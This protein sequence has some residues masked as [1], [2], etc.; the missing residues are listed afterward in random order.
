MI[1]RS[2]IRAF[3]ANIL[4]FYKKE[5]RR[6]P[7]RE[8]HDPYRILVSEIMLQ[9]TQTARVQ[10]KYA[11]FLEC[12][13]SFEKLAVAPRAAV[14]RAWQGLGYNRR[15]LALH[16]CACRVMREHKGILPGDPEVLRELPG[17]GPYT[18]AAIACFAWSYPSAFI[19][20][21]IRTVFLLE[22]FPR[23]RKVSDAEI[24][25]LVQSTLPTRNS[26][27]WYYALM[28]YG[29]MLK[30]SARGINKRSRHYVRQ[31]PFE[32]SNRQIR[33]QIL[34]ELS[35]TEQ[36]STSQLLRKIKQPESVVTANLSRL[37][38]EGFIELRGSS[39]RLVT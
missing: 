25:S 38:T 3:Q 22:F 34:R 11:E 6:F 8:T 15:A 19:E 18:A 10:V 30:R 26:R 28:D 7:W 37:S 32:G 13:P 29:V 5:G 36:L 35:K 16:E 4:K 27:T 12:F 31:T 39:F 20:T 17:V 14:L 33:G 1:S 2:R 21:N 9:Q 23:R 24:L